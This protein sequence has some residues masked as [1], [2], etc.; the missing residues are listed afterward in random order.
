MRLLIGTGFGQMGFVPKPLGF[1]L[2]TVASLRVF[3]RVN[4][5]LRG[6]HVIRLRPE[7]LVLLRV[8]LLHPYVPQDFHRRAVLQLG[9]DVSSLH[10]A[11]QLR[12]ILADLQGQLLPLALRL[13]QTVLLKVGSIPFVPCSCG[14]GLQPLGSYPDQAVQRVA[15][16]FAHAFQPIQVAHC[17][18]NTGRVDALC[19]ALF[20]QAVRPKTLQQIIQQ[21]LCLSTRQQPASE[22]AQDRE[23]KARIFKLQSQQILP[24]NPAAHSIRR[25]VVRQAFSELQDTDHRQMSRRL[26]RLTALWKQISEERVRING[27][28]F[29]PQRQLRVAFGKGSPS[30]ACSVFRYCRCRPHR[31]TSRP[32]TA[33]C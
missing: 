7:E 19:A 24:I 17:R 22:L 20:Q 21:A 1:T 15:Q 12:P 13:G 31:A 32:T 29:I 6:G 5:T 3:R 30:Y 9:W 16:G 28:Q 26:R 14:A 2:L 4:D 25:L 8:L 18:L 11:E 33:Y 27:F 23:I 10:P